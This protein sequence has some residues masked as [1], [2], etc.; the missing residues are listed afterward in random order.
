MVSLEQIRALEARVEKAVVL[1][2]K[3][4]RENAELEQNLA[5]AY[6][7]EEQLKAACSE[8]ERQAGAASN[9][10][11]ADAAAVSEAKARSLELEQKLQ[12]SERRAK[13][14]ELKAAEAEEKLASAERKAQ[15]AEAES[16]VY[17]DRALAAEHHAAELESRA[18]ELRREQSRIEEGL[19]SA[20]RKLDDFEDFVMGI[21]VPAHGSE[22][23]VAAAP[24][25]EPE[26]T[27]PEPEAGDEKVEVV[28]QSPS[29][30]PAQTDPFRGSGFFPAAP[31][32]SDT[33]PGADRELDIF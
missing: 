16:V 31:D 11:A 30:A 22:T 29:T 3:L 15:A 24:A 23:E 7:N 17:R 9:A 2:D 27:Q 8:L 5:E 19:S 25:A 33:P 20:L 4:R 1:I 32:A 28:D 6:R 12:D 14:A 26:V 18:E 10:A 21:S 13:D